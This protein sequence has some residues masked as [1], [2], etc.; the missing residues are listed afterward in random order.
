[1]KKQLLLL[2]GILS[3]ALSCHQDPVTPELLPEYTS[4]EELSHGLIQLGDKLEDPYTVDNMLNAL[5]AVY[6]TK[7]DRV[8]LAAT[9][10]YVRF[11]PKDDDQLHTLE[12]AGL[13]LMDHPMD[14]AIL[15]EGDYYQDPELEE[16]Q[17]TWQYAVVPHDFHFPKNIPVEVLDEC[18]I[19]EHAPVTRGLEDIDWDLVERESFRLTGNG[20]MLPALTKGGAV[21][22]AGRITIEDPSYNE[23]KPFG[24]SGVKVACNIFVK[25]ATT[26]T[27]RDGYY[28]MDKKFSGNPRYRLVFQNKK[29]FNIGFNF[30]LIPASVSTLGKAGPEGLDYNIDASFDNALFRRCTVNNAAYDYF[31]RCTESDLNITAPPSNLRIWIFPGLSSSSTCML[32][33]GAL[34][35]GSALDDLLKEYLG[36]SCMKIVEMFLPDLTIGTKQMDYRSIYSSVVH[37]LAHASHYTQVGNEYWNPYIIYVIRSFLLEGGEPYGGG[38]GEDKGYCEIGEMW[39]YFMESTLEKDRYGGT[40]PSYGSEYWFKPDIFRYLYERGFS[41]HDLFRALKADV[42]STDDLKESLIGLYPEQEAV[43]RQTFSY[44]G[45]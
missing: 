42:T 5:A 35:E 8:D 6:P 29:G 30:I 21:A 17:I 26:Y 13:Y 16:D 43:I 11:L 28:Q 36:F 33:H 40:L 44:Y 25:I 2:P 37:E 39:G 14:Y 12:E 38:T 18:Y 32:R 24:V 23:G 1:M 22:P 31:S 3:L 15:R 45:K 7:A 10:L 27:D 9:D 19:A 34:L 41:R 4:P 20:E